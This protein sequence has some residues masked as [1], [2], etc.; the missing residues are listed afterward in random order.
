MSAAILL[1][2]DKVRWSV[3]ST[4]GR[5]QRSD[6]SDQKSL[7]MSTRMRPLGLY[8]VKFETRRSSSNKQNASTSAIDSHGVYYHRQ[9]SMMPITEKT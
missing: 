8:F 2:A 6:S 7:S 9:Y 5:R 4:S 1:M 3:W